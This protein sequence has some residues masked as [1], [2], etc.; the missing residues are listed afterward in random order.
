MLGFATS[1]GVNDNTVE[2]WMYHSARPSDENLSRIAKTLVVEGQASEREQLARELRRLYWASDI[3]RILEEYIDTKTLGEILSRLRRYASLLYS[4]ICEQTDVE[5]HAPNLADLAA[6]G[7]SS[8]LAE[9]LLTALVS[10]ES[11]DEWR[12]DILAAGSNWIRR[13]LAVNL[14]V[15]WAEVD[16]LIQKTDGRVLKDW[17]VNNPRAY[18]H[19][20]RSMEMQTQGRIDEALAEV[21]KAAELDPLD[22]ANHYT[23]GSVKGGIGIRNSD[24]ALVNEGIEACWIAVT[25]AGC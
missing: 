16:T 19:Y 11:D 5:T 15:H 13:V 25:L 9:P 10:R 14:Q 23:L 7:A 22:P 1:V 18:D 2:A 21:A 24:E 12:E 6:L 4:I 17:D 20:Q 8:A 3:A